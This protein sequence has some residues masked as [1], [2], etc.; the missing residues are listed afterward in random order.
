MRGTSALRFA[1]LLGFLCALLNDIAQAEHATTTTTAAALATGEHGD[2][3][4]QRD[5]KH[6]AASKHE[7]AVFYELKSGGNEKKEEDEPRKLQMEPGTTEGPTGAPT[8]APSTAE[9]GGSTEANGGGVN[10]VPSVGGMTTIAAVAAAL[11]GA[12]SM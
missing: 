9:E 3:Q 12:M 1:A 2:K 10:S 7:N 5:A 4:L 6:L 11:A 8:P